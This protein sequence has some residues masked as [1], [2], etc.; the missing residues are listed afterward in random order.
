MNALC[1]TINRSY[2]A[3]VAL[4]LPVVREKVGYWVSWEMIFPASVITWSIS[5]IFRFR[6]S[7]IFWASC[8]VSRCSSMSSLTYRR[9]PLGE[10]MRPAE[11][12]GC[13]R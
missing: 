6:A 9:Y 3:M 12:W 5:R 4:R 10:G 2:R 1:S 7:L 11:V 8:M 13:S